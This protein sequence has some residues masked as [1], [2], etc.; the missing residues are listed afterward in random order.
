MG[1]HMLLIPCVCVRAPVCAHSG[2]KGRGARLSAPITGW[3]VLSVAEGTLEQKLFGPW[4]WW[5]WWLV[6]VMRLMNT[7]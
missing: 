3:I 4:W 1:G 7:Y 6:E 5:W 2:V